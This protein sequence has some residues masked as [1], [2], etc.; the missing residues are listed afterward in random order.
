MQQSE[1]MAQSTPETSDDY[2]YYRP[3]YPHLELYPKHYF[4]VEN[5]WGRLIAMAKA[6]GEV[7]Y[8]QY[9]YCSADTID[10]LESEELAVTAELVPMHI[11]EKFH[12]DWYSSG[13]MKAEEKIIRM[14]PKLF[15]GTDFIEGE[16]LPRR[17]WRDEEFL[18]ALKRNE[19][20]EQ[21]KPIIVAA[22]FKYAC[23]RLREEE[24]RRRLSL[25]HESELYASL[26]DDCFREWEPLNPQPLTESISLNSLATRASPSPA[27]WWQSFSFIEH[28]IGLAVATVFLTD[29]MPEGYTYV[30]F[31]N[32][33]L[34]QESIRQTEIAWCEVFDTETRDWE[35]HKESTGT[36]K[37]RVDLPKKQY[38]LV[39]DP[40]TRV[41]LGVRVPLHIYESVHQKF[42][43]SG[44]RELGDI[45]L[46][47][48]P[49]CANTDHGVLDECWKDLSW[50][51]LDL[52][53]HL[54]KCQELSPSDSASP[55]EDHL[56][57]EGPKGLSL[58]DTVVLSVFSWLVRRIYWY[59][60]STVSGDPVLSSC[61]AEAADVMRDWGFHE[62]IPSWTELK[63]ATASCADSQFFSFSTDGLIIALEEENE[64]GND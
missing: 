61:L 27:L 3:Y 58:R 29:P 53:R 44:V 41:Y 33:F 60:Y 26:K 50:K 15:V 37:Q 25:D 28:A 22:V 48:F 9:E 31:T 4:T 2:Q 8:K 45:I 10:D 52:W 64:G 20:W 54:D 51:M 56:Q 18:E 19:S 57:V 42:E 7:I 23:Q 16:P 39:K 43:A 30:P 11:Y 36:Y 34:D 5:P 14:F 21:A 63:T 46:K 1:E 6:E 47:L 59:K 49:K 24:E 55:L 62:K 12:A 35:S 13:K 32:W 38:Y 40:A 17:V